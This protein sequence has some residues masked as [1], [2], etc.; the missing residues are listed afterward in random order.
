MFSR[1]ADWNRLSQG[2]S[3]AH[4]KAE[5]EF[6]IQRL[7]R[8]EFWIGLALARLTGRARDGRSGRLQRRRPPVITD[9]NVL[10]IRQQRIVGT[11]QLPDVRGV[12][13]RSVEIRVVADPR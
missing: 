10:V 7:G 1:F 8:P 11:E 2:V 5:F 4:K 13:N 3:S 9:G 6:V 12:E